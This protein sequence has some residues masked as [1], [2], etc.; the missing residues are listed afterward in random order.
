LSST[1]RLEGPDLEALLAKV[2]S[3]FGER[4]KIVEANRVRRGGIGGFFAKESFEVVLDVD[5][6]RP[7]GEGDASSATGEDTADEREE[8][9]EADEE[10]V[11]LS[12]DELATRVDDPKPDFASVLRQA[13]DSS[14]TP[15]PTQGPTRLAAADAS[16]APDTD[17]EQEAAWPA[18]AAI[19][20][21]RPVVAAA[22]KVARLVHGGLDG[23]SSPTDVRLPG[24][25]VGQRHISAALGRQDLDALARLGVPV[26]R[27]SLPERTDEPAAVAIVRL[28]ERLP[29]PPP[30][31]RAAGGVV[32]VVGDRD[33][34]AEVAGLLDVDG[35]VVLASR[36]RGAEL[37]SAADADERRRAWRRRKRPTVV[38]VDT[39]FGVT[40]D[41]WASDVLAAL[42]PVV[43]V[44]HVDAG[45]KPEDIRAWADGLGGLDAL[46]VDGLDRTT[47]P[48]AV[49][50]AGL[51]VALVDGAAA[52][53]ARWAA[54]LT[55]R[56]AAVAA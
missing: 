18:Q 53:P 37:R 22:P 48:A 31:P 39:S 20:H 1:Q 6:K 35:D 12:V 2:R 5:E 16:S 52:T 14:E 8:A 7:A 42:E 38:V 36:R 49:L 26:E 24:A 47:T 43:A 46:A 51:P 41:P 25:S 29:A 19:E 55:D 45:R 44:G 4:A 34:A 21:V 56:L 3:D 27:L 30:M 10:F 28:L 54:L 13:V 33:R 40:P 50:R 32:A 15:E 23:I 17:G 9:E 11:P